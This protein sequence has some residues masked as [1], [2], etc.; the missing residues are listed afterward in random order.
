[1]RIP[2]PSAKQPPTQFIYGRQTRYRMDCVSTT[3]SGSQL[4]HAS[5]SWRNAG[6]L[7]GI[8]VWAHLAACAS[9][10]ETSPGP[11][12][13]YG[14]GPYTPNTILPENFIKV[15]LSCLPHSQGPQTCMKRIS[16]TTLNTC[17]VRTVYI[18]LIRISVMFYLSLPGYAHNTYFIVNE[19]MEQLCRLQMHGKTK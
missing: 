13:N 17:T 7:R 15:C 16:V 10:D 4:G 19:R 8:G 11:A 2:W 18:S 6:A 14:L 9:R 12:M 1:M 3:Y 5:V